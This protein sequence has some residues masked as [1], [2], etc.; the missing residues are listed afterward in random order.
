[1]IRH[2]DYLLEYPNDSVMSTD[3][4]SYFL[5][6]NPPRSSFMKDMTEAERI[7]MQKHVAYWDEYVQD[8]TVI[9]LGPVLDPKGGYGI[10]VVKVDDLKQLEDLIAADPANGLNSYEYY[11]MRAVTKRQ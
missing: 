4:K 9:V 7:I 1:M 5:K 11:P 10:A 8:G 3:K 2:S 6:L